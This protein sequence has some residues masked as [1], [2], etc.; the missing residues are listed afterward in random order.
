MPVWFVQQ[1]R[2]L[3][4]T[5]GRLQ[6]EVHNVV[7]K[8]KS[9]YRGVVWQIEQKFEGPPVK[10]DRLCFPGCIASRVSRI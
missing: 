5:D 10:L 1:G 7:F 2:I 6:L 3:R 9:Y 8:S 4:K